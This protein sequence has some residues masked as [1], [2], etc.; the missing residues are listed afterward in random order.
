M[1]QRQSI[2]YNDDRSD[3]HEVIEKYK[4]EHGTTEK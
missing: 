3:V 1:Q 4:K 2:F